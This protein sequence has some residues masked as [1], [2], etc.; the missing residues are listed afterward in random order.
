LVPVV[1]AALGAWALVGWYGE[2]Q[3]VTARVREPSLGDHA[4]AELSSSV[5]RPDRGVSV[6]SGLPANLPGSWSQFRGPARDGIAA[7]GERVARTWPSGGPEVLWRTP[8]GEG[9]A[10]PVISHGRVYLVDYDRGKKEDAIRCLSLADGG[11]IWR[12]S[13]AVAIKR[14]HGMSRT[15]PAV[16]GKFLVALGPMCQVHCLNAETGELLWKKD[17]V[18]EFGTTVP[19]WYAGQSPLIDQG[20]A[21]LAPGGSALSGSGAMLSDSGTLLMAVDLASGQ[22]AWK[23]PNPSGWKMT[24]SSI[25]PLEFGGVRQYVYCGSLGVIS[26]AA[27]DGRVLWTWPG[28]KVSNATVPTP[29]VIPPDR[30]FFTGGYDAGSEMVQL[31]SDG[32]AIKVKEVFRLT[33]AVFA[34]IQQTP[35]LYQDHIYGVVYGEN[36]GQLT[37]LDL[38]GKR[39][40]SSGVMA[41]FGLGPLVVADG[42]IYCLADESGELVMAEAS[43]AGYHE[44]GRMKLLAGSDSWAPMAVADGRLILREGNHV[45]DGGKDLTEMICVRIGPELGAA[46][47]ETAEAEK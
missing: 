41:K 20:R 36:D 44:L 16:E 34:C 38:A 26:V 31:V 17:L 42:V 9:H 25:M 46:P 3:S 23:T 32:G 21:I 33:K 37:C 29:V 12:Y 8:V 24:H 4:P 39:L 14:N 13:Y 28:W 22:V 18:R 45:A 19:P 1:A 40:W 6:G 10:G 5:V 43:P 30:L 27:D 2:A 11:E 15:T 7:T 47:K 35:I